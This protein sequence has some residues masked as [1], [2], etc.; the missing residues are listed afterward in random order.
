MAMQK[1][2]IASG[3]RYAGLLGLLVSAA[4]GPST[5]PA[6][7]SPTQF[8]ISYDELAGAGPEKYL[9]MFETHGD[10]ERRLARAQSRFDAEVG[11]LQQMVEQK[12]GP[13]A[14]PTVL[15]AMGLL[16]TDDLTAAKIVVTG[17]HAAVTC[18]DGNHGPDL[19]NTPGGWKVDTTAFAKAVNGP[20]YLKQLRQL[21]R[22]VPDL[23]DNLAAGKFADPD[24]MVTE[25]NH[26]FNDLER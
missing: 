7:D 8:M 1:S 26:R 25:I 10:D 16:G 18:A 22:L 14:V 17:D 3:L 11:I 12:W 4:A 21:I 6:A 2:K 19:V 15:H 9:A 5:T 24:A 13:A 23:A 20:G